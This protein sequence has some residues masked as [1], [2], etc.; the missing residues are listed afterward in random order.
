MF[1]PKIKDAIEMEGFQTG[2]YTSWV[3]A[4]YQLIDD[5]GQSA[6][7]TQWV[8]N[9][10]SWLD[11]MYHRQ[12]Y[13]MCWTEAP[14]SLS[15]G[16][17][18][19]QNMKTYTPTFAG[20]GCDGG[21]VD[22]YHSGTAPGGKGWMDFDWNTWQNLGTAISSYGNVLSEDSGNKI[23][24]TNPGYKYLW[25][26]VKNFI[27]MSGNMISKDYETMKPDAAARFNAVILA[28]LR[29]KVKYD[30]GQKFS[31]LN[32]SIFD[33]N[34]S[35]TTVNT[36]AVTYTLSDTLATTVNG[37]NSISKANWILNIPIKGYCTDLH[38][39][40]CATSM[41]YSFFDFSTPTM[42]DSYI[43]INLNDLSPICSPG[44]F[45]KE[46]YLTSTG[47]LSYDSNIANANANVSQATPITATML[48]FLPYYT[49]KY[50]IKYVLQRQT[51]IKKDLSGA[52]VQLKSKIVTEMVPS[53]GQNVK[54][55]K[56]LNGLAQ[57]Y[58]ELYD[59][60]KQIIRIY[61][62]CTIGTSIVDVRCD[63]QTFGDPAP[64]QAALDLS[65]SQ[66]IQGRYDSTKHQSEVDTIITN[67]RDVAN[68]L[69]FNQT[70]NYLQPQKMYD[71]AW[72]TQYGGQV[73]TLT[74]T[75]QKNMADANAGKIPINQAY[76]ATLD[77]LQKQIKELNAKKITVD[78]AL[79]QTDYSDTGVYLRF[80]IDTNGK[81]CGFS[82]G[83]NAALTFNTLYNS[84]IQVPTGNFP[85]TIN[86]LPVTSYTKNPQATMDCTTATGL[87]WILADYQD[88]A[89]TGI[90]G[91]LMN[92]GWDLTG[93]LVVESV[94]GSKQLSPLECIIIWNE[95]I[96][97][98][99]NKKLS[100]PTIKGAYFRYTRNMDQW[101]AKENLFDASGFHMGKVTEKTDTR[102]Q[103]VTE[104]NIVFSG[105]K[106]G[107]PYSVAGTNVAIIPMATPIVFPKVLV[108]ETD[109]DTA[110]GLCPAIRCDAIL[111]K[112]VDQF[113]NDY[114]EA[115]TILRVTKVTT[116]NSMQCDIQADINYDIIKQP[117]DGSEPPTSTKTGTVNETRAFLVSLDLGTCTYRA[118]DYGD[119]DNGDGNTGF[120]IQDT[121]PALKTP[122]S[123]ADYATTELKTKTAALFKPI[124]DTLSSAYSAVTTAISPFRKT[125][126]TTI[127]KMNSF[128]GC[129]QVKCSD[130]AVM[131]E[132]IK[133]YEN[134]NWQTSRINS[135]LGAG[136][137]DS[138]TC[139][140]TYDVTPL[141]IDSATNAVVKGPLKTF[142]ARCTMV[143][144][145]T[146]GSCYY[147]VASFVTINPSP[148]YESLKVL[149]TKPTTASMFA[150]PFMNDRPLVYIDC[151]SRLASYLIKQRGRY[152]FSVQT[153]NKY[154]HALL[155][156]KNIDLQTCSFSMVMSPSM[157][158][159]K[160][161]YYSTE[162]RSYFVAAAGT[163]IN[164]KRTY[165]FIKDANNR[166]T[167]DEPVI[168]FEATDWAPGRLDA[169]GKPY[170]QKISEENLTWDPVTRTGGYIWGKPVNF[171]WKTYTPKPLRVDISNTQLNFAT[172]CPQVD[173]A[174]ASV[175]ALTGLPVRAAGQV[176]YNTCEFLVT[177]ISGLPF[178]DSVKNVSFYTDDYPA[179]CSVGVRTV[180]PGVETASKWK[181]V[182]NP[183][184]PALIA[185]T[186]STF[187]AR[188]SVPG[189]ES[190]YTLIK[191]V[192]GGVQSDLTVVYEVVLQEFDKDGSLTHF[193]GSNADSVVASEPARFIAVHFR[194]DFDSSKPVYVYSMGLLDTSFSPPQ[195]SPGSQLYTTSFTADATHAY[196][197]VQYIETKFVSDLQVPG[198]TYFVNNTSGQNYG[199]NIRMIS[200]ELPVPVK[201]TQGPSY[202]RVPI[203]DTAVVPNPTTM[204]AFKYLKITL[205]GSPDTKDS[206][207]ELLRYNFYAGTRLLL[208]PSASFTLIANSVKGKTPC[209]YTTTSSG[210][211]AAANPGSFYDDPMAL[212][213]TDLTTL[214]HISLPVGYSI[215]IQN[216][217]AVTPTAFSFMTGYNAY[218]NPTKWLV[219]G[220]VNGVYWKK[221]HDQRVADFVY[222]VEGQSYYL[223]PMF[224]FN[225]GAAARTQLSN[226]PKNFFDCGIVPTDWT[227]IKNIYDSGLQK[228]IQMQVPTTDYDTVNN[229]PGD[230]VTINIYVIGIASYI[231]SKLE[232]AV[233]YTVNYGIVVTGTKT[234]IVRVNPPYINISSAPD[235]IKKLFS[236]NFQSIVKVTFT[237]AQTCAQVTPMSQVVLSSLIMPI[238][239]PA[240]VAFTAPT[241]V[242]TGTIF[243]FGWGGFTGL[244]SMRN[245][246]QYIL[247]NAQS[248]TVILEAYP[249]FTN[250]INQAGI[251]DQ[252]ALTVSLNTSKYL[253]L[254]DQ[255]SPYYG[256]QYLPNKPP[257]DDETPGYATLVTIPIPG[258]TL[259]PYYRTPNNTNGGYKWPSN[260]TQQQID[261]N[262]GVIWN[263]PC[264]FYI[265]KDLVLARGIR[266]KPTKLRSTS[267]TCS[268][269]SISFAIEGAPIAIQSA[270]VSGTTTTG[271]IVSCMYSGTATTSV[272]DT[273]PS[274]WQITSESFTVPFTAD[275]TITINFTGQRVFDSYSV[276]TSTDVAGNDPV[277]W[278]MDYTVDGVTWTN[279]QTLTA[280]APMSLTRGASIK[281]GVTTVEPNFSQ[282]PPISTIT[283]CNVVPTD[284]SVVGPFL[285]KFATKQGV[286][287]VWIAQYGYSALTNTLYYLINTDS[288]D[289]L[290]VK[291]PLNTTNC[292]L[293]EIPTLYISSTAF[294][295]QPTMTTF[296]GITKL[297]TGAVLPRL[298]GGFSLA[299][300][301][302]MQGSLLYGWTANDWNSANSLI[303]SFNK[304]GT[305]G[306]QNYSQFITRITDTSYNESQNSITYKFT[307]G[308]LL[309][310]GNTVNPP[311]LNTGILA[312]YYI[313]KFTQYAT[314]VFNKNNCRTLQT[315][316]SIT[317]SWTPPPVTFSNF[318][319]LMRIVFMGS[320]SIANGISSWMTVQAGT[321]TIP[322]GTTIMGAGVA[323]G[324]TVSS[325]SSMQSY[326]VTPPQTVGSISSPIMLSAQVYSLPTTLPYGYGGF[327]PS[328]CGIT[329]SNDIRVLN[330]LFAAYNQS[331]ISSTVNYGVSSILP[332]NY[333]ILINDISQHG[334]NATTNTAYYKIKAVIV[335]DTA[336]LAAWIKS[337]LDELASSYGGIYNPNYITHAPDYINSQ[338]KNTI[339]PTE[340]SSGSLAPY[341]TNKFIQY[342]KIVLGQSDCQTIPV[343][344]TKSFT[345]FTDA[346]ALTAFTT[347]SAMV[348]PRGYGTFNIVDYGTSLADWSVISPMIIPLTKTASA[349]VNGISY[350]FTIIPSSIKQYAFDQV[351]NA[352]YYQVKFY[353]RTIGAPPPGNLT[354]NP[355][356]FTS[357]TS[358][359][360][361]T[362]S[363][364]SYYSN[365][366][367]LTVKLTYN[368][369]DG[370]AACTFNK[371]ETSLTSFTGQP[372]WIAFPG[373]VN[374]PATYPSGW[375]GMYVRT[376]V[377]TQYIKYYP[378]DITTKN[379]TGQTPGNF[380]LKLNLY[381][382]ESK[383]TIPPGTE[384]TT[385]TNDYDE[386]TPW[387]ITQATDQFYPIDANGHI[388]F[389][390]DYAKLNQYK[391]QN[392]QPYI[393]NGK[394]ARQY[395]T[396]RPL[397]DGTDLIS[398]PPKYLANQNPSVLLDG[399][400]ST[401][402]LTDLDPVN[403]TDSQFIYFY[404]VFPSPVTFDS[405]T[406]TVPSTPT[407]SSSV[408]PAR[409]WNV[410]TSIDDSTYTTFHKFT[411]LPVVNSGARFTWPSPMQGGET[412][413]IAAS[414]L[415]VEAP[416]TEMIT[417]AA[418]AGASA[419]ARDAIFTAAANAT[420]AANSAASTV[421]G[422]I[423]A[424]T[425]AGANGDFT[426]EAAQAA[427][428]VSAAQ[429]FMTAV[430]ANTAAAA[431]SAAGS[432]AQ[433]NY[434]A[435]AASAQQVVDNANA[436]VAATTTNIFNAA[437]AAT[438][439]ANAAALA[440]V[441]GYIAAANNA[442][443]TNNYTVQAAQA[444]LAVSSA[445]VFVTAVNANMAAANAAPAGSA[446]KT[447]YTNA[448]AAA[449]AVVDST[450]A[451]VTA[452]NTTTFNAAAAATAAAN[453]TAA[454]TVQNY[455]TAANNAAAQQNWASELT[456]A[457][458]AV[459]A[460]YV[461]VT[462]VNANT[463]AANASP[464]G[465]AA[466]A[467]YA[468]AAAAAQQIV[469]NAQ[470]ASATASAN[471][472]AHSGPG[473]TPNT[474]SFID[475]TP[476]NFQNPSNLMSPSAIQ[477]VKQF[478]SHF[479]N[480]FKPVSHTYNRETRECQYLQEDSS[481]VS[482]YFN[483]NGS[484]DTA[485][486]NPH[487]FKLSRMNGVP[488]TLFQG[489]D[490]PSR[491]LDGSFKSL[492]NRSFTDDFSQPLMTP[493]RTGESRAFPRGGVAP[494]AETYML[495]TTSPVYKYIRIRFLKTRVE[496]SAYVQ[497]AGL[498][499]YG[500]GDVLLSG[501]ISNLMGS[502]VDASTSVKALMT[503][504][505]WTDTN[506]SPLMISFDEP[507][508]VVAFGF[509][510]A[511]AP[512]STAFDP[513]RWK[514]EGSMNGH[515]WTPLLSQEYM[516]P[517]AR[518]VMTPPFRFTQT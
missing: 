399:K 273:T 194:R 297:A 467:T 187:A 2:Q 168:S 436:A 98:E 110:N 53:P 229:P 477:A 484:I 142:G 275:L 118:N 369:T 284:W 448:A 270:V 296:T 509:T 154:P 213:T 237:K 227:Y 460:S 9:M 177:D 121:T 455:I 280:D 28:S 478:M 63:I 20:T 173:C 393:V 349:T 326:S 92:F 287:I 491:S 163:A 149:A 353:I 138:Q 307:V 93:S 456:L 196:E 219:E 249:Y 30:L 421:Q 36:G 184:D 69:Q 170:I 300:C 298:W 334:Y 150:T 13:K 60:A 204:T 425:T 174:S 406:F 246:G 291:L 4:D 77:S 419:E 122:F 231:I 306:T 256:R 446:A 290:Y 441:Q 22:I 313:N 129:S 333:A 105:A 44:L 386:N 250:K 251:R 502:P 209:A 83:I 310:G 372:A 409:G 247:V 230:S 239:P 79:G 397:Y 474:G 322:N 389:N 294:P 271:T 475:Y 443:Q 210:T 506:K 503:G 278:T 311:S 515:L 458:N 228:G 377:T 499:L 200:N 428:A 259:I 356:S 516:T 365:N 437:T 508:G 185:L 469:N 191:F 161:K 501:K 390:I 75:I 487:P 411:M 254:M 340:L 145:T 62:A 132:F 282:V 339:N 396:E 57:A 394:Y 366:F 388:N 417:T 488:D 37:G 197:T 462:A 288:T 252:V 178:G 263:P 336:A 370:T 96:Y 236:N 55:V 193:Y 345:P 214:K 486:S 26:D 387:K 347:P 21:F 85:G 51:G 180:D 90:S 3:H 49:R 101:Y 175:Q 413:I 408:I 464:V 325:Y 374:P 445:Q 420:A 378:L 354:I 514:V 433:A 459:T 198:M 457:A 267:T 245:I 473:N 371:I 463:A 128:A 482:I 172:T 27:T 186:R 207:V 67:Y 276:A 293:I 305:I 403:H 434:T 471:L 95:S 316:A 385:L 220:S 416:T 384:V 319:S 427:L 314:V 490:T 156:A 244:D 225:G 113:N 82:E 383:V 299:T 465:S 330:A 115:G 308:L 80:F 289:D 66:Y 357:V 261:N 133:A 424:A 423:T 166:F 68:T 380:Y 45:Q 323:S 476:E 221:L 432:T 485:N 429:V 517:M 111:P 164:A 146:V 108:D 496:D 449:K 512:K 348:Q 283:T 375:G 32:G 238:V 381:F 107:L 88:F 279:F 233:Y 493:S 50:I 188:Y 183:S 363:L 215:L 431:A 120:S 216:P 119:G 277:R 410:M 212:A 87:K 243:P 382:N 24:N 362:P 139:D 285:T 17:C 266:L 262:P 344:L 117:P 510:T 40:E 89:R 65:G 195:V 452:A 7:Y 255:T 480:P 78:P 81:P 152:W 404:I 136:Q 71:D 11:Y 31:S 103:K 158:G 355:V 242:L 327:S 169:N 42:M 41:K 292:A 126:Y 346:P 481:L 352:V 127:G 492:Y 391:L 39:T 176:N 318:N 116:P 368:K 94:L 48:S 321:P 33:A 466:R 450:T 52:Y 131:N 1:Y 494:L 179:A 497:I 513:V 350:N 426:T 8:T 143:I 99:S 97:D 286:N 100:G 223:S 376:P 430:Q 72:N 479:R 418:S 171:D 240:S 335:L 253:G 162:A 461:F 35:L 472:A 241:N 64:I 199:I 498:Q 159:T 148:N 495:T 135:I 342:V 34:G 324:T 235:V 16:G 137:F 86:Y 367:L 248:T 157:D 438:A 56:F 144:D 226:I 412:P 268:I 398:D 440:V 505:T 507:M 269:G 224:D 189:S 205:L 504:G 468:A 439:A 25:P 134:M 401:Y 328:F 274:D 264:N 301:A 320:I 405:F 392:G 351:Q 422:Y 453:A 43:R 19:T 309:A 518:G 302:T 260:P 257:Y 317:Y 106:A 332:V 18:Y 124:T 447:I 6:L 454:A 208:F 130:P 265:R 84:Y 234:S 206:M 414:E 74:Q 358:T 400:L 360:V 202:T 435:A 232:N 47:A 109:L 54:D 402:V 114:N 38:N 361:L 470:A 23:Y 73:A 359:P 59:G 295:E 182:P 395:Y 258:Q 125:T 104:Y 338:I 123:Y 5:I 218:R 160:D 181:Y 102:T 76:Y 155:D 442:A 151:K 165:R 222:P 407:I 201:Y 112:L 272:I 329:T 153:M 379:I 500:P 303:S 315:V 14:C 12:R 364:S 140:Y 312:D 217:I 489:Q 331:N 91:E 451:A 511:T 203:T 343:T 15:G 192:S 61:D 167:L 190:T 58:Y 70:Q 46:Y 341:Y 29:S 415:L 141:S 373:V 444:A 304:S 483:E 147:K 337:Q 10:N 211:C 281:T